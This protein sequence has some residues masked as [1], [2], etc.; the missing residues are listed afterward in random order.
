MFL[1]AYSSIV[2]LLVELFKEPVLRLWQRDAKL[3]RCIRLYLVQELRHLL[4]VQLTARRIDTLPL[5][6]HLDSLHEE[7]LAVIHIDVILRCPRLTLYAGKPHPHQVVLR[8]ATLLAGLLD[9]D[10]IRAVRKR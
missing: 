4:H 6:A 5:L 1:T 7:L 3:L 9:G 8:D 10:V 2:K